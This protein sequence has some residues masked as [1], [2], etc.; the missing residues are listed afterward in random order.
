M[1]IS[2]FEYTGNANPITTDGSA[3]GQ[4][5][6]GA[7]A[8]TP[9]IT[10]TNAND[11]IFEIY[12]VSNSQTGSPYTWTTATTIGT[13]MNN[14]TFQAGMFCGQN[15][16]SSTQTGYS[17]T[18]NAHGSSQQTATII[19]AFQAASSAVNATVAQ[20]A[21]TLTLTGGT[22]TVATVNIVSIT[23]S[24]ANLTSTGGT[25][26]VASINDVSIAQSAAN[27]TAQGGTQTVSA[28]AL[29][30]ASI[31]QAAATITVTGGTGTLVVSSGP[32]Q[33]SSPSGSTFTP[34]QQVRSIQPKGL[35]VLD[36]R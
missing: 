24:A 10:T 18:G 9:A 27:L 22:Q 29:V 30:S 20:V 31:S 35:R 34:A 32:S 25:Q 36:S 16:V 21:A 2:I 28:I 26:V 1:A 17:D 14:G 12:G 15:I 33:A 11:L 5:A 19:A 8:T 7:T 6:T 13:N 3:S 23:Q 4:E